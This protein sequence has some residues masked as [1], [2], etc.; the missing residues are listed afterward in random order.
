MWIDRINK[1]F[2]DYNFLTCVRDGGT[3]VIAFCDPFILIIKDRGQYAISIFKWGKCFNIKYGVPAKTKARIKPILD[4]CDFKIWMR[5][6]LGGL[7]YLVIQTIALLSFIL[8]EWTEHRASYLYAQ[9]AKT[10]R[11]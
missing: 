6:L 3:M 2:D 7:E 5:C 4:L 9:S 8:T 11:S 10:N 1:W